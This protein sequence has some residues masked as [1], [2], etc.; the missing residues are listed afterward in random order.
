MN[1]EQ[2]PTLY[3]WSVVG[4]LTLA[5]VLSFID[6][7]ILGMLITPIK[8]SL[9]LT[10][11]E[12]G[13]LMGPA[14]A[15]FYVTLGWPIGWMADRINRRNIIATGIALWSL[16]TAACGLSMNFTQLL[17][18]RLMVGVGEAALTPS[19]LSLMADYFAPKS[20][21][22]A[23]AVY[24]TGIYLGSGIAYLGGGALVGML[25]D[26]GGVTLPVFGAVEGWQAA[27]LALGIPG[28][29]VALLM[30]LIRE[31]TRREDTG[32]AGEALTF[33][34]SRQYFGQRW[35]AYLPVCLGMCA[36]TTI[37]YIAGWNI[38]WFQRIWD[39]KIQDIGLWIGISYLI[40]GPLGTLS[41]GWLTG[42]WL[43]HGDRGAPFKV[44]FIGIVIGGIFAGLFPLMPTPELA[45]VINA[46]TLGAG[47]FSTAA[48]A[49]SVVALAPARLRAQASAI[50]FLIINLI[51]LSVGPPLVGILTDRVF[52][53]PSGISPA[54]FAVGV[55]I[56]IPAILIMWA[57][58]RPYAREA[59]LKT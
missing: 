17:W 3:A 26:A 11:T 50:Y 12:L 36:T 59:A 10:D 42:R 39:W 22:R 24:S 1:N 47:A 54:L 44:C 53:G 2:K 40:T 20:R 52:T 27:F 48:G 28:V 33:A 25:Q 18:S 31:P 8:A 34:E 7:Q 30:L 19:A 43:G 49:T 38:V 35:T 46:I 37:A 23:I 58:L 21:P 29:L 13:L 41:A 6:R 15:F 4:M 51:G 55:G 56:S 32:Q 45:F 5:Y 9:H 14:F 16:A 57:G